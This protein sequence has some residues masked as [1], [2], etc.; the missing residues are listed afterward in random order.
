MPGS[1]PWLPGG[2]P[3]GWRVACTH[4]HGR[5]EFAMIQGAR[6]RLLLIGAYAPPEDGGLRLGVFANSRETMLGNAARLPVLLQDVDWEVHPGAPAAPGFWPVEMRGEFA[7]AGVNRLPVVREACESGR[8][9]ALVLLGGGDPGFPEAREIAHRHR[10]VVTACAHAQMHAA[11]LLGRR[12]AILDVSE[13]HAHRM[14]DLLV[15]YRMADR[16]AAIRNLEFPLPRAAHAGRAS[17]QDEAERH[18]R[19]EASAMLE[20]AVEEAVSAIE[21][22]GAECFILGCSAAYWLQRPLTRRLAALGWDVPVLEGYGAAVAQAKML[23]GLGVDA[24]GLAFPADPPP[25][26]RRRLLP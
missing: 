1:T 20:T 4:D 8:W 17:V 5:K 3:G 10:I 26:T 24:S 19:G 25:R 13:N 18:A 6:C 14:A 11:A 22:D 12:F 21:E 15:Q 9:D 23:V 2:S 7:I 16:C